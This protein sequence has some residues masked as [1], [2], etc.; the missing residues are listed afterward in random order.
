MKILMLGWE[1]PPQ[2]SGGLGI[3][4]QGLAVALA[5]L[6]H[7]V[8]FVLP[9]IDECINQGVQL[10]NASEI[11]P[12]IRKQEKTMSS[13][14]KVT[15]HEI[16]SHLVP[17]LGVEHFKQKNSETSPSVSIKEVTELLDKIPLTGKFDRNLMSEVVKF[18]YLVDQFALDH[19]FDVVHCHDWMTFKAGEAVKKSL[20]IPLIAHFHSIESERNG[21]NADSQIQSIE[22]STCH[23]AEAVVTVSQ[24]TSKNIANDYVLEEDRIHIVPNG[25]DPRIKPQQNRAKTKKSIG[26]VGRF[27]SQKKPKKFVDLAR[28]VLSSR[29]D[30]SFRMIG[31]GHLMEEVR[32]QIKDQNLES[33]FDLSGFL[34]HE[35]TIK[36]ISK[37]DLLI[38]PS[39]SE[40]FGLVPME[41]VRSKVPVLIAEGSGIQEFV[42]SLKTLKIWD[43]FNWIN[44]IHEIL[45]NPNKTSE[46][47][48]KCYKESHKMTW[49][50]SGQITE[51][52]YQKINPH[53]P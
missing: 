11:K 38:V 6:G 26:F 35:E 2:I 31:D 34:S 47:I 8:T 18:A 36:E 27:T 3:A 20:K 10:I 14:E 12:V 45:D 39:S 51:Q 43:D 15:F 7:E 40:P 53:K 4:S 25:Y 46:M 22:K 49:L 13:T 23:L 42:P 16:G 52:L 21:G 50:H 32:N 24:H 33:S 30:V 44:A 29:T 5:Q 48:D 19:N 9:K 28:S 41:A 17:Y 37:L 1:Y